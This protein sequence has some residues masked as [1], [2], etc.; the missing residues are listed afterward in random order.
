MHGLLSQSVVVSSSPFVQSS[1][2]SQSKAMPMFSPGVHTNVSTPVPDRTP[3]P[4]C[5]D[6]N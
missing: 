3:P 2:P 6:Y 5:N 4:I 1:S